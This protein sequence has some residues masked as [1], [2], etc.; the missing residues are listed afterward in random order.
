MEV[1]KQKD[2]EVT[3][4]QFIDA[5][6]KY[7]DRVF[8][9]SN[10]KMGNS[11]TGVPYVKDKDTIQLKEFTGMIGISGNR[12]G[13]VYISGDA[14]LFSDLL[15]AIV[16]KDNPTEAHLLDMAGEISNVVSGNVRQTFGHDF[17]IT[18]PLVFKG[19]PESI[20][21]PE[22]VPVFVIPFTWNNNEADLVIG[23]E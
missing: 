3:C 10:G 6:H 11:E 7:F 18:V 22:N 9:L 5:I 17:M 13:F 15:K 19:K 20:R 23:L 21:F 2:F 12:K 14:K 1:S 4:Q 16:K 8:E